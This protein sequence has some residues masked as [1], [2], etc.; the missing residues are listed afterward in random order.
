MSHDKA[1]EF[2]NKEYKTGEHLALSDEQA[3]DLEKFVRWLDRRSKGKPPEREGFVA[4]F[5]C[6]NG[7]N[8]IY[9]ARELGMKGIGYDISSEAIAQ[10]AKAAAGL[11]L[12]FE[13]RSI[14]GKFP[15]IKDE[16]VDVVLD[17]MTSHVLR[18]AERDEFFGELA[19]IM[20]PG[21]WLFL[22]TFLADEDLHVR[23][24]L[25][26][27]PADEEWSYMHPALGVFEHVWTEER[28]REFLA[29]NFVIHKIEKSHKHMIR[30]K[31]WKRRYIVM[32]C[33]RDY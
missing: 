27:N 3:S 25:R 18:A 29:P 4:D 30:G 14:T 16:S 13:V 19:R 7:R 9:M 11:P 33:E 8:I 22:K 10:A 21:A 28:L 15:D 1:K 12:Q 31:A 2:W 26:D 17:M 32:Y 24:L 23:R 20:K 5:G 6:G